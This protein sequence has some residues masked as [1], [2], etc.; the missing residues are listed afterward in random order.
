MWECAG[1][2]SKD[3]SR[4]ARTQEATASNENDNGSPHNGGVKLS[5]GWGCRAAPGQVKIETSC[6]AWTGVQLTPSALI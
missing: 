6:R 3:L 1:H 4:C 2:R 5:R